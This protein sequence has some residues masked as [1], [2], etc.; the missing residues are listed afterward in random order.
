MADFKFKNTKKPFIIR[1]ENENVIFNK[2]IDLGNEGTLKVITNKMKK[3][4]SIEKENT[5][6]MIDEMKKIQ[7]EVIDGIFI[8]SF[9][10]LYELS[11]NNVFC[12]MQIIE[13]CFNVR[14]N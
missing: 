14:R 1:D 11:G 2:I 12:M 8:D 7:K 6:N 4:E 10:K 9:D 13:D 3:L 5:D